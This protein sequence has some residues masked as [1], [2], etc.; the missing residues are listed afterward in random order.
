MAKERRFMLTTIDNPF[1]PFEDFA[2]WYIFDVSKGYNSCGLL[3]ITAKTSK[4]YS[5]DENDSLIE[6]AMDE[7]VTK[8]PLRI[9]KKVEKEVDENE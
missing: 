3:A 1:D 9:Y 2:A 7:I 8:N 4:I 6:A 5:E